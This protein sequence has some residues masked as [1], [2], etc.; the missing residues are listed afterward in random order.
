MKTYDSRAATDERIKRI[1]HLRLTH[2]LAV[3]QIAERFSMTQVNVYYIL[4]RY[5]RPADRG[6]KVRGEQ[7]S[8]PNRNSEALQAG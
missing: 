4:N 8:R 3:W 2:K 6:R 1:L 5:G 7:K